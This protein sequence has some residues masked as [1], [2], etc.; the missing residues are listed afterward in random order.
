MSRRR[1]KKI[2]QSPESYGEKPKQF[3]KVTLRPDGVNRIHQVKKN[4]QKKIF[5]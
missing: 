3:P 2:I 5:Y 4:I 1:I